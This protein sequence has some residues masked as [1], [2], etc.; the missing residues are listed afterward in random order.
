[1]DERICKAAYIQ[2]MEIDEAEMQEI[3]RYTLRELQ[4]EEVFAFKVC[5]CGN[6]IDRDFEAFSTDTLLKL[7]ELYRGKS[8]ISDHVPKAENQTAR[9]Y[10]T[11]VVMGK[12]VSGIGEPYAQLVGYCYMPRTEKNRDTITEIEAGIKKEVSVGCAVRSAVCSICGK[13]NSKTQCKHMPGKTYQDKLCYFKLENPTD[14]YELSFVAVPAQRDAGV[15]KHYSGEP[16]K[17]EEQADTKTNAE[18]LLSA[19]LKAF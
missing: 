19:F 7:A 6:E 18:K 17:Q 12:D 4:P 16:P 10:R 1:M 5:M 8:V 2:K 15:I 9:I 3:N 11:E 13:D 14:A